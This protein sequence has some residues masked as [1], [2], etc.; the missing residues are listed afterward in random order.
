MHHLESK[1]ERKMSRNIVCHKRT[2]LYDIITRNQT[3]RRKTTL[4]KNKSQVH[5]K[6][7]QRTDYKDENHYAETPL[8]LAR[9]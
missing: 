9:H 4:D 5:T 8:L 7:K 1:H 6:C 3:I 2:I